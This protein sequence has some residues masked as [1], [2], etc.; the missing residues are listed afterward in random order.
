[1]PEISESPQ[2]QPPQPRAPRAIVGALIGAELGA[3]AGLLFVG[4]V[5]FAPLGCAAAG[6][7]AGPL[8]ARGASQL[9]TALV[10]RWLRVQLR[11][12]HPPNA[13]AARR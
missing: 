1:M 4:E 12:A 9:R 2:E 5:P 6:A 10:G 8:A 13:Q 11:R 3:A 7:L